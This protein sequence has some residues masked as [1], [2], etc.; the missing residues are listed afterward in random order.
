MKKYFILLI[1]SIAMASCMED[2]SAY[3]PQEKESVVVDTPAGDPDPDPM[4]DPSKLVPGVNLVTLNVPLPGSGEMVERKFKYFMPISIDPKIPISLI[5]EFHQTYPSSFD[6][7]AEFTENHH[8][9]NLATRKNCIIVYPLAYGNGT[10]SFGWLD[11]DIELPFVDAMMSYFKNMEPLFDVKLVYSTGRFDGATFCYTMAIKRSDVFAAIAPRSGQCIFSETPSRPVPIRAFSGTLNPNHNLLV[12]HLV[13]IAKVVGDYYELDMKYDENDIKEF[14]GYYKYVTRS[15]SGAKADYEI[16]SMID[17]TG[18]FAFTGILNEIWDFFES[19][20]LDRE[21]NQQYLSIDK[22]SFAIDCGLSETINFKTKEGSEVTFTAPEEWKPVRIGNSITLSAPLDYISAE[23]VEG[24][25][26]IKSVH[27]S[28][29][30]TKR[31]NYKLNAPKSYF[32]V[33]DIYYD[34]K[35]VPVGVVC[36]VNPKNKTE[37]KVV[38]KNAP[39]ASNLLPFGNCDLENKLIT[40]STEKG[41]EN[42]LAWVNKNAETGSKMNA[43]NSAYMWAYELEGTSGW[44][45]PAE[46]EFKSIKT[47]FDKINSSLLSINGRVI[48]KGNYITSTVILTGQ[49]KFCRFFGTAWG[50]PGNAALNTGETINYKALAMKKVFK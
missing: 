39:N 1:I 49:V 2:T 9:C 45:L 22:S 24:D 38:Y 25:I 41:D 11:N 19:H 3:L 42:T 32:E 12:S 26:I 8:L 27:E 13:N 29:T 48:D 7:L 40:S 18:N 4:P 50:T 21:D 43:S 44:Y 47:N 14:P 15:F 35:Y 37:A 20:P 46:D 6:V 31:I 5:F 36:W 17:Q 30:I 10:S 16:Y 28:G 33:G 23:N 34:S